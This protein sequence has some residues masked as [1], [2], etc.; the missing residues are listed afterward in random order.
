MWR[1]RSDQRCMIRFKGRIR[2]EIEF[3]DP[4]ESALDVFVGISKKKNE[5]NWS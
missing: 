1:Y 2:M 5:Q 3:G 4:V